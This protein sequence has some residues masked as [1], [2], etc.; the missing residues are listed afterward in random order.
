MFT[1][2]AVLPAPSLPMQGL[3]SV[4]AEAQQQLVQAHGEQQLFL[5]MLLRMDANLTALEVRQ[6]VWVAGGWLL[7]SQ[8]GHAATGGAPAACPVGTLHPR[9]ANSCAAACAGPAAG[10]DG[11]VRAPAAHAHPSGLHPPHFPLSGERDPGGP[12]QVTCS[13]VWACIWLRR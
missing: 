10:R 13:C 7:R 2:N 1:S 9:T 6:A 12:C 8:Q 4:V 11:D 3:S 5:G